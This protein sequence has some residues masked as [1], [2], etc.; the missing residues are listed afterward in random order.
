MNMKRQILF[1][2]SWRRCRSSP[3]TGSRPCRSLFRRQ[4][5]RLARSRS[6]PARSRIGGGSRNDQAA[7]RHEGRERRNAEKAGSNAA[8]IGRA[9]KS[10]G[11][12]QDFQQARLEFR[13]RRSD[14]RRRRFAPEPRKSVASLTRLTRMAS[15]KKAR[16]HSHPTG[17]PR[18]KSNRKFSPQTHRRPPA[19]N[20]H[21]HDTLHSKKFTSRRSDALHL[22]FCFVSA[23]HDLG[24]FARQRKS[25]LLA[26]RSTG[27]GH[28]QSHRSDTELVGHSGFG[29]RYR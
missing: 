12:G 14:I 11:A 13:G 1:C 27:F 4:R 9:P 2:R 18:L 7:R 10:C 29:K 22:R 25:P 5:L 19:G 21:T 8:A 26:G 3:R 20:H 16:R 28:T 15:G 24:R 23:I 6:R 17:S